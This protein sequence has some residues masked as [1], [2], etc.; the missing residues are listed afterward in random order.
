MTELKKSRKRGASVPLLENLP[1]GFLEEDNSAFLSSIKNRVEKVQETIEKNTLTDTVNEEKEPFNDNTPKK[2]E[3]GRKK[4]TNGKK[5]VG[6][7]PDN[8]TDEIIAHFKGSKGQK[9]T[10]P[11]R[12]TTDNY[13][14]LV[15]LQGDL[16]GTHSIRS[17]IDMILEKSLDA[18]ENKLKK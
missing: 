9:K 18:I 3:T 6:G 14:R 17:L 16:G 4:A 7:T 5:R 8:G 15:K 2:E 1:E 13:D 12:I 11:V 10:K